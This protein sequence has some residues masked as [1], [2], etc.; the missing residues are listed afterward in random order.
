MLVFESWKRLLV[1]LV[2]LAGILFAAPNVTGSRVASFL[3]GQPV[4]LGLD[5]QGGSHLLLRV[6]MQAVVAEKM[7]GLA[8]SLRLSFREKRLRF[9]ALEA[10]EEQVRFGLRDAADEPVLEEILK[11][12]A[13]D[14]D[15]AEEGLN[16][17]LRFSET[18]LAALRTQTVEQAIEIIRRRLDPDGTKEPVI[19]RQGADR[20]LVQLP[21]VDDPERVK[22]LLGQTARLTFQLVDLRSSAAEAKAAGRAPQGTQLLEAADGLGEQYLVER[23]VMVSG[24]MLENASPSFDQNNRPAVAFTLNAVGAKK[25]AQVT[26]ANIGRPFAIVLDGKV[27]SAPV[28]QSQIFANGQITGNFTIQESNDLALVLRAGALPAPLIVLEERSVGPGL[29]ADSIAAGTLAAIVGLIL[30]MAYMIASYGLFGVFATVALAVNIILLL[31]ALSAIQATLTLPGIAGIVLTVGMAVDANVLIFERIRE[32]FRRGRR[33]QAAIEAGYSRAIST[34]IDSNLTTLVAA[35]FLYVFG[36]G[37]VRG[38]SVTLA[39]GIITSMFTAILVTRLI[40]VLWHNASRP[41]SL[42]L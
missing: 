42:E 12:Y 27:V 26:G 14:Y 2:V 36:S 29:G 41:K 38:F 13:A 19:Q 8:D 1:L 9:R 23:R 7:V 28:I 5:L 6:D 21:G 37:P 34:I 15:L 40:V 16:R 10:G 4:N 18:G 39:L 22:S 3:P 17:V 30:V 24:D 31:A 25:F 20:V 32:E 11:A 35:L 33:I